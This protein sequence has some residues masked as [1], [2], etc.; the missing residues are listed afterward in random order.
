VKKKLTRADRVV[1]EIEAE[2]RNDAFQNAFTG[3]GTPRDKTQ[4]STFVRPSALTYDYVQLSSLYA[5]DAIA[6]RIVNFE[7]K[8]MFRCGW[9]ISPKKTK[10]PPPA[11][12]AKKASLAKAKKD[13][14]DD[15]ALVEDFEAEAERL[16]MSQRL[17]EGR[18]WGRLRG[19]ALLIIGANDGSTDTSLPLNEAGIREINFLNV[20]DKRYV[21]ADI[22]YSDPNAPNY[23]E[24]QVYNVYPSILDARTGPKGQTGSIRVHESRVIRFGGELTD[25]DE[26]R[27]NGGWDY[28]IL[29]APYEQMRQFA[30]AFQ[31]AGNLIS[32]ASQ[33]VMKIKGLM[34]MIAGKNKENLQTRMQLVDMSRSV[35]RSLLLDA[36]GESFERIATSFAGLPDLLDRFMMMLSAA[37]GI[38]V[39]ILMGRSAAGMNATGDAD[40]RAFYATIKTEQLNSLAPQIQRLLRLI[41]LAKK[42]PSRG[43]EMK[44]DITFRPLWEPSQKEIAETN[45]AQA[46]A[47]ASNVNAEIFTPEEIAINRGKGDGSLMTKIDVASREEAIKAGESFDSAP[48]DPDDPP[49]VMLAPGETGAGKMPPAPVA[50]KGAKVAPPK[51]A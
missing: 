36:D 13:A 8:E 32:D 51:A 49:P 38:P 5:F 7:P 25:V 37:S 39:A 33:G 15:H 43:R 10:T 31:A 27:R 24:V 19:G 21:W 34:A 6:K 45:Q 46:S 48:N 26:R 3:L 29:E 28:S 14:A 2:R 17:L 12:G 16:K 47:D 4:A 40:F 50:K 44:W 11:V 35:A 18:I 22:Y 23:G 20:I 1:A 41:S 30:Q 9:E 42:G